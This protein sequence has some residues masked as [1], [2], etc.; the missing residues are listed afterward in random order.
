MR[1]YK[2]DDQDRSFAVAYGIE[3]DTLFN[4]TAGLINV[5]LTSR[6][7][8]RNEYFLSVIEDSENTPVWIINVE[9]ADDSS[10]TEIKNK[11]KKMLGTIQQ[12]KSTL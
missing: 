10:T 12:T 11:A 8:S 4:E 1:I 3:I 5:L 7:K 9:F 2:I 6:S